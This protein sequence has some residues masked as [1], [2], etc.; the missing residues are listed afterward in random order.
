VQVSRYSVIE[1]QATSP[2]SA[3]QLFGSKLPTAEGR[4]AP[5]QA[6]AYW[7]PLGRDEHMELALV[8]RI[9][10]RYGSGDY[11]M[12]AADEPAAFQP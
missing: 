5:K 6:G 1:R 7:Q 4:M 12:V 10:R 11:Q 8:D 3:F 2:A 9:L